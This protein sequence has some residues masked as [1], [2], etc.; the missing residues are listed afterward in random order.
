MAPHMDDIMHLCLET[1]AHAEIK[2]AV[3][4]CIKTGKCAGGGAL[5]GG[6]LGGPPGMLV[7][8]VVGVVWGWWTSAKFRPVPQ[9]LME[10]SPDQRQKLYDKVAPLLINL[11]WK[12]KAQLVA[13]VTGNATLLQRVTTTVLNFVIGELGSNVR[14][15]D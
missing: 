6:L 9:I 7:G 11:V 2:V 13:L 5:V 12:K 1:S 4:S 8:G 15:R 3:K 10:L 14:Q